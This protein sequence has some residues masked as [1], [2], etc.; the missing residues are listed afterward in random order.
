MHI[1]GGEW[2]CLAYWRASSHGSAFVAD[3]RTRRDALF[4]PRA[5][6]EVAAVQLKWAEVEKQ[7]FE[8]VN[9]VTSECYGCTLALP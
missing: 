3:L 1:I 6:P 7:Q 5:F 9:D 4:N 2:I 8:F